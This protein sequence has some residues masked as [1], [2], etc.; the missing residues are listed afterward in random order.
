MST[1]VA[2]AWPEETRRLPEKALVAAGAKKAARIA[3]RRHASARWVAGRAAL[4]RFVCSTLMFP[5]GL[6]AFHLDIHSSVQLL[7]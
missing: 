7:C 5:T 3:R 1:L 4:G 6:V 2:V